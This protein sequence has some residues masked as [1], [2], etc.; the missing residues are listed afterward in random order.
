MLPL[1]AAV[2]AMA[3]PSPCAGDCWQPQATTRAWQIQLAG[4]IDTAVDAPVV[5]VDCDGTRRRTIRALHRRGIRVLGYLDAGSTES[6]RS[7]ADRFPPEVVGNV[8]EGYPDEHWLDIRR[9]DILLPIMRDRLQRCAGKGFDGADP[10]NVN[11]YENDTGFPLTAADQVTFNRALADAAHGL[12]LAV[13]L[14]NTGG[15]VPGLRRWFDGA[16]VESCFHYHECGAYAPF[17]NAGKPVYVIEYDTPPAQFCA[18]AR[19]RGFSAIFKRLTLSAFR[20]TC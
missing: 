17:V 10:D 9:V 11:G 20:R 8:Y 13:V 16:V 6:Y 3:A 12:G 1:L 7:D 15:L 19:R 4:K 5:E 2:A 14:K 18:A